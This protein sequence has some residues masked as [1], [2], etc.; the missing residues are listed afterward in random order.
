MEDIIITFD[1]ASRDKTMEMLGLKKD[2]EGIQDSEGMTVTDQD[3]EEMELKNFGGALIGS[4]VFIN[5]DS[6][7]LID[8]FSSKRI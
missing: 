1:D 6:N 4:K 8:Y 5:K 7:D 2:K 3:F